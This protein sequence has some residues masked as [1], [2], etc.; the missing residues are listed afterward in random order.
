M[1]SRESR[2]RV[3]YLRIEA[4]WHHRWDFIVMSQKLHGNA[5]VTDVNDM[6][7]KNILCVGLLRCFPN[8]TFFELSHK[9]L[10]LGQQGKV[11]RL[12]KDTSAVLSLRVSRQKRKGIRAEVA[13]TVEG[14]LEDPSVPG[15]LRSGFGSLCVFEGL[16]KHADNFVL[17]ITRW[18]CK[19]LALLNEFFCVWLLRLTGSWNML[20][21]VQSVAQAGLEYTV[22]TLLSASW[23]H[24]LWVYV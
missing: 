21:D 15:Q 12:L 1:S 19:M 16:W 17:W 8:R 14:V 22:T 24:G 18:Q 3:I 20:Q 5:R 11:T 2:V 9:L 7:V 10:L 4:Q 6:C 13:I 23:L